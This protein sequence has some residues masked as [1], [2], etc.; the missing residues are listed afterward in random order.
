MRVSL[1][2]DLSRPT[3][4]GRKKFVIRLGHALERMGVKVVHRD[5][6][7]HLFLPTHE[8]SGTA[9]FNLMRLDGAFVGTTSR[10]RRVNRSRM[11]MASRVDGVVFQNTFC[12]LM[13]ER[14]AGLKPPVWA[15]I[16]NGAD[17]GEF[18]SRRPQRFFLANAHWRPVK[19]LP[20]IIGAFERFAAT[21]DDVE[22]VVTGNVAQPTNHPRIRYVGLQDRAGVAKLLS[23]AIA[24]LHFTYLDPCPNAMV[25]AVVAGC[26][27]VYTDSGGQPCLGEGA[28]VSFPD[29][30]WNFEQ[31][32][33]TQPP[34]VDL[35]RAATA[36][37]AVYRSPPQ[38]NRPDL[39]I[40]QVA[41]QYVAF[42]ER[43]AHRLPHGKR[44]GWFGPV[45][46]RLLPAAQ[47]GSRSPRPAAAAA[48]ASAS[49]TS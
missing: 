8:P 46:D 33:Q 31:V 35:D 40:D 2:V 21:V 26:P 41:R 30:P 16:I 49:V 44:Q 3:A 7:F 27:V 24:S 28:G 34:A 13:H 48:R 6:D 47:P 36:M 19:R 15:E 11:R 12:R 43:V 39:H 17:P 10:D 23:G 22:L 9:R 45:L 32:C 4:T 14:V 18:L 38:V 25:E 1:S 37:L 29:A 20:G 5:A 42:F